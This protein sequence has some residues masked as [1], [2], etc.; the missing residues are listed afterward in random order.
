MEAVHEYEIV[1]CMCRNGCVYISIGADILLMY[2]IEGDTWT[3]VK[4]PEVKQRKDGGGDVH[5]LGHWEGRIFTTREVLKGNVTVW[6][7][8]NQEWIQS[9]IISG[10]DYSGLMKCDFGSW[11]HGI[12]FELRLVPCFCD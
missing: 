4:F 12:Y 6:E 3:I 5:A 7:L 9:G 1:T 2:S 11:G 8:T 10:K